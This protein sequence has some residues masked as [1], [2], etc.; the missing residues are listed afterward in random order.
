MEATGVLRMDEIN[1][2]KKD[3]TQGDN[4]N[5]IA[6]KFHRSWETVNN[7]IAASPEQVKERGKRPN[8]KPV[9]VTKEV[10]DEIYNFLE[11]QNFLKVKKKQKYTAQF[12]YNE[13]KRKNIYKGSARTIR[14]VVKEIK[15][16]L[17]INIKNSYLP[18]SFETGKVIQIDHG[19]AD[20]LIGTDR[21]TGY[22]F[23]GSLPGLTIRYCQM[24][25]V[26]TQQ[27][28]GAFGMSTEN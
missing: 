26:K 25:P 20:C 18:L 23:V 28:W 15:P 11:K 7:V 13:L 2:I 9:V 5:R 22:L 6:N 16:K 21:I 14:T 10:R 19:E 3:F 24:Y 12:I 17:K 1:K 27:A 8:R 4:R